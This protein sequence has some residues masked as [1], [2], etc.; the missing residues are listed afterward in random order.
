MII[1]SSYTRL[2]TIDDWADEL[3]DLREAD[4]VRAVRLTT[5]SVGRYHIKLY[6]EFLDGTFKREISKNNLQVA[7]VRADREYPEY[8]IFK[9]IIRNKSSDKTNHRIV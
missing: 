2:E 3:R 6:A 5:D 9:F 4:W 7:S 8:V 1:G